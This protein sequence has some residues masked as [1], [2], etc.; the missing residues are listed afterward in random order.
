MKLKNIIIIIIICAIIAFIVTKIVLKNN[1]LTVAEKTNFISTLLEQYNETNVTGLIRDT[2]NP[3]LYY[4]KG[5]NE[6]VSNNY[7]WYGGHLWRVLEFN[8]DDKTITLISQQPL[9]SIE[10]AKSAWKNQDDYEKSYVNKWLNE[11]FWNS[12]DSNIQKNLIDNTFDIGRSEDLDKIENVNSVTTTKKVGL[13]EKNQYIRAGGNESYLNIDDLFLMSNTYGVEGYE[14]YVIG[15][16]SD[17][18]GAQTPGAYLSFGIRP[19]IKITDISISDGDGTLKNNYMTSYKS[20]TTSN[21]QIGEYIN[22]PN[23]PYD[24]FLFCGADRKCT[25]RVVSKDNDSIKV[26]LN[27]LINQTFTFG[28]SSKITEEHDVYKYLKGIA[29]KIS[30]DY[31]YTGDKKF[32][33]GAYPSFSDYENVYSE[34]FESDVGLPTV[35]EMFSGND[36]DMN[37]IFSDSYSFIDSDTVENSLMSPY[38]LMNRYDSAKIRVVDFVGNISNYNLVDNAF[39]RPVIFLKLNLPFTSGDGTA[40]SP[41]EVS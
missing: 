37:S 40:Q 7:L 20:T 3:N 21:V 19:V 26:V 9:T 15:S 10:P 31:R 35:G 17:F 36:I 28:D 11:Y 6:D 4:Y 23:D 27:G 25:F 22:V 33:V 24:F 38:F 1:D 12:L 5:N 18:D 30:S 32:G 16:M 8:T 13:L 14:N 41:Y 2:E 29:S 39:V 34:I